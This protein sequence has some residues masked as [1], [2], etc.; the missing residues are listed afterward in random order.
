MQGIVATL[1]SL[2]TFEL[3][4]SS[5]PPSSRNSNGREQVLRQVWKIN[6]EM[7]THIG[8]SQKS[9][10]CLPGHKTVQAKKSHHDRIY[11]EN[12]ATSTKLRSV[13]PTASRAL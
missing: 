10:A 12:S 6:I 13:G 5:M 1:F 8:L 2:K 11:A 3:I 4:E 7:I 9:P